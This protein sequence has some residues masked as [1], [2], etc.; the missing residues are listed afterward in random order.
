MYVVNCYKVHGKFL[1]E[2]PPMTF[3]A[4]IF[5]IKLHRHPLHLKSVFDDRILDYFLQSVWGACLPARPARLWAST[6]IVPHVTSNFIRE[7]NVPN[8]ASFWLCDD[9][10]TCV[11]ITFRHIINGGHVHPFTFMKTAVRQLLLC[12]IKASISSTV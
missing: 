2:G 7:A 11:I 10:A 3:S 5:Q 9:N 1:I 4:P 6:T 12:S 8:Q